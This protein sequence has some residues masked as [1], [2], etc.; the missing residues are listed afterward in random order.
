MR[1]GKRGNRHGVEGY[2]LLLELK[3]GGKCRKDNVFY[4]RI[5]LT[6]TEKI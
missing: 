3:K 6:L 5:K 2:M 1:F 4:V